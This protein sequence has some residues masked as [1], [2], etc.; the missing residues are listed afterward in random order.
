[1]SVGIH[2]NSAKSSNILDLDP[3]AASQAE[4]MPTGEYVATVTYEWFT[5]FEEFL[6]HFM[7]ELTMRLAGVALSALLGMI[8]LPWLVWSL[9][10]WF[11]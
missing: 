9:L 1:M 5:F 2:P 7:F 4:S 6:R 10:S 8:S 3:T 11:F